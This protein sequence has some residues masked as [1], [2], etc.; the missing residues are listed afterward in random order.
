MTIARAG[1]KRRLLDALH[2]RATG[3]VPFQECYVAEE[4]VDHVLGRP[5]GTHMLRLAPA[6]YVEFLQR[7]GMDAAY[8]YE[9]WFLGRRT[10]TDERGRVHYIDGTIK[11]RADF[12]QIR[13]PSLDLVRRRIEG[14]LQA[15]Q[16][17][18]LGCIFAPDMA[19]S[20]ANTAIGP[21]DFLLAMVDDP[22]FVD[23]FMDRVEA[24]TLPLVECAL[25]YPIDAVLISG[26]LCAKGGPMVSRAMHDRFILPRLEKVIRLIA[27]SSVPIILHTDGDNATL[28]D[29]ILRSGVAA[30]HPIEPGLPR[31]DIYDLKQ[32]YGDALCLWGNV[33]VAGVLSRGTPDQVRAETLEHLQHLSPGGGY[34]CSSSH[35]ITE[36]VPFDNFR[37]LAE[38]IC[39]F[40]A[41]VSPP[42]A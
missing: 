5:M 29:W 36:Q 20:M 16:G 39:S 2:H 22:P 31:F 38:T 6:D 37:A 24:Y 12:A 10:Q 7:T 13:P 11:T 33:D 15:A 23:E 40:R 8:L 21:T 4:I 34:I 30:L 19:V 35:D 3:E 28:M 41:P 1:H 32:R 26:L 9:G 18:D 25:G 17:T 27:P 14:W 42:R